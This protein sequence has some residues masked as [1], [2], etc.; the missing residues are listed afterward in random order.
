MFIVDNWEANHKEALF[1]DK[2]ICSLYFKTFH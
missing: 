1:E 2:I